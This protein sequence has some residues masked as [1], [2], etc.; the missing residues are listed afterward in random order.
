M[1]GLIIKLVQ[2]NFTSQYVGLQAA[3]TIESVNSKC[4]IIP[5]LIVCL[6]LD[7]EASNV[8]LVT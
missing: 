7:R 4:F 1:N 3:S 6:A 5:E 8:R 2:Y